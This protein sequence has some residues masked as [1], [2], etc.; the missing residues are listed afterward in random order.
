MA[1]KKIRRVILVVGEGQTEKAFLNHLK[2]IFK[3]QSKV[4]VK[5]AGGKGPD[6]VLNSALAEYRQGAFSEICIFMDNDL[7]IPAK[8]LKECDK[9]GIQIIKNEPCVEA[10]FLMLLGQKVPPHPNNNNCKKEFS[11]YTESSTTCSNT[12]NNLFP[13]ECYVEAVNVIPQIKKLQDFYLN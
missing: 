6:N 11:K 13:A 8:L 12:Y 3:G 7:P 1:K 10:T 9:K 2:S 4:Q 5:S